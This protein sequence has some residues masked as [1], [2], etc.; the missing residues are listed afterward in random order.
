MKLFVS[1]DRMGCAYWM[2]IAD[3]IPNAD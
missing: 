1:V 2:M 3:G